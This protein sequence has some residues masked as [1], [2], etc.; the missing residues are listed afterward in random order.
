MRKI[1]FFNTVGY[2]EDG[3][4]Q[5]QVVEYVCQDFEEFNYMLNCIDEEDILGI[6]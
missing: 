3:E 5:V 6:E 2:T 4:R 1:I